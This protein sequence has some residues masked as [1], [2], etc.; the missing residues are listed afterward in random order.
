MRPGLEDQVATVAISGIQGDYHHA[1]CVGYEL[2]GKDRATVRRKA[3]LPPTSVMLRPPMTS[4][5]VRGGV[6]ELGDVAA[7]SRSRP[8]GE[9]LGV[10]FPDVHV[11]GQFLKVHP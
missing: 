2:Y 8:H 3:P 9:Q 5:G 1:C 10:S 4:G 7:G 6:R 11:L